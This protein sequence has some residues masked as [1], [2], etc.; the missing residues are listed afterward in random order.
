[1]TNLAMAAA[2]ET[3]Y[4]H[5]GSLR[6]HNPVNAVFHHERVSGS[7]LPWPTSLDQGYKLWGGIGV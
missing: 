5:P 4:L 2:A 6:S 7:P 1:M 3:D